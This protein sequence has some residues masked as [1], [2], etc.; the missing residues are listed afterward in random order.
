MLTGAN[1][2]YAFLPDKV[3]EAIVSQSRNTIEHKT[4]QFIQKNKKELAQCVATA[5]Y[6]TYQPPYRYVFFTPKKPFN[7]IKTPPFTIEQKFFDA[8][9]NDYVIQNESNKNVDNRS[10]MQHIKLTKPERQDQNTTKSHK[11]IIKK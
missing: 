10:M 1:A 11:P 2:T 7:G 3:L 6:N 4:E 9:I 5:F 8:L